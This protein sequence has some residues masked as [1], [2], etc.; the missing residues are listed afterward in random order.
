MYHISGLYCYSFVY[1][2]LIEDGMILF[3]FSFGNSFFFLNT[4]FDDEHQKGLY[5]IKWNKEIVSHRS[6]E[7][8]IGE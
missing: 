3:V 5:S 8:A 4:P 2:V 6:F 1:K 7:P